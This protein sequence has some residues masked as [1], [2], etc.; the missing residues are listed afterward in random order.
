LPT[1]SKE[2]GTFAYYF[3]LTH[4]CISAKGEDCGLLVEIDD[5]EIVVSAA[6]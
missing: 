5:F 6:R 4:A 3:L 1:T 2:G